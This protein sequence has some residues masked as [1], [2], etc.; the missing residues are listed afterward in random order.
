MDP[1]SIASSVI[2]TVALATS[3]LESI[4]SLLSSERWTPA[5]SGEQCYLRVFDPNEDLIGKA[6]KVAQLES[7]LGRV[8]THV[9]GVR[10]YVF[11]NCMDQPSFKTHI[12]KVLEGGVPNSEKILPSKTM[13]GFAGLASQWR[14]G[15]PIWWPLDAYEFPEQKFGSFATAKYYGRLEGALALAWSLIRCRRS[16]CITETQDGGLLSKFSSSCT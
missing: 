11:E 4:Q 15:L 7:V 9:T 1:L 6:D 16:I 13:K 10:L 14:Q 12:Q 5:V 3:F 2:A 8:P